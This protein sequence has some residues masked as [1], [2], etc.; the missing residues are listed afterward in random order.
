MDEQ[1]KARPEWPTDAKGVVTVTLAYPIEASTGPVK[2]V[3]VRRPTAGD[4]RAVNGIKDEYE[5]GTALA[6]AL[7]GMTVEDFD[8][9]DVLDM[10]EITGVAGRMQ[11]K[12]P[13]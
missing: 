9:I 3:R 7:I 2:T 4:I 12:S 6:Q 10:L 13:K 1:K 11:R 8:R 5:R